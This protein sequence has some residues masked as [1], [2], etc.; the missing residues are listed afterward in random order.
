MFAKI[1]NN[2]SEVKTELYSE[3]VKSCRQAGVSLREACMKADVPYAT[4]R[5]WKHKSPNSITVLHKLQDTLK[6]LKEENE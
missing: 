6:A 2:M 1:F 5:Y 4:V 3:I